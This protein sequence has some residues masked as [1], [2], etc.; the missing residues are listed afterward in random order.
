MSALCL[1]GRRMKMTKCKYCKTCALYDKTSRT[2]NKTGGMYYE[3]R[4]AG[5]YRELEAKEDE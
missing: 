2:C 1:K 3:G 4:P 5:C